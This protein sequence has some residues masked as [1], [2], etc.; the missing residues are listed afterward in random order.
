LQHRGHE[1]QQVNIE[2]P[3]MVMSR[4]ITA[5]LDQHQRADRGNE[6][7]EEQT[8]FVNMRMRETAPSQIKQP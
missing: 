4:Q 7:R 1:G 3:E 5:S 8:E 2:A 6:Q